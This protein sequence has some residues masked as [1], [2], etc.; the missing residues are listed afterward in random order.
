MALVCYTSF[1]VNQIVIPQTEA[2]KYLG[3]HFDCRLNWKEHIAKKIK[4]M[5]LKTKE[6]NW[7]IGK[8]SNLST[9]NKLPVCTAV[10]KPIRSYGM[11]LWGCA[12]K[13]DTVIMRRS[14]SKILIATA[15]PPR[16]VTNRTLHTD[17]NIP[18]V[19]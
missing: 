3:L 6:V 11:E 12:G 4:Q 13:S 1:V 9:E 16:C 8:K 14:Q 5:D 19:T 17:C 18:Y 15:N 2:V 7:L 10:I